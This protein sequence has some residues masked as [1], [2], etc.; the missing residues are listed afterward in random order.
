MKAAMQKMMLPV[1]LNAIQINIDSFNYCL[2]H[3]NAYVK[4]VG[5]IQ[6]RKCVKNAIILGLKIFKYFMY[7]D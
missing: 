7:S 5:L 6:V 1:V 2:L 4:K 3:R